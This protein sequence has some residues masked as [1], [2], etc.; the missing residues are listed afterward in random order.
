[1]PHSFLDIDALTL[2]RRVHAREISCR[3]VMEATL[4]RVAERNPAVTAIV[5]LR[6]PEALLREADARDAE[7]AAGRSRGWMHGFPQAP[8]DLAGTRDIATSRGSPLFAGKSAAADAASVERLVGAGAILIGKTN[9]PEFGLG[10]QTY[11]TVFGPTGNAYDPRLTSGGS[12]GGAAVAVALAMLPVADGSDMMGSLRNPAAYNNIFGFRPSCGRVPRAPAAEIFFQQLGYEG[13]MA[14]SVAD[15]ARLLATMAGYDPRAPLSLGDDPAAF[16][17]PLDA[18]VKDTRIGWLGDLGGYL[19][20][21]PGILDLC[22]T[23]L[24][25]FDDLGCIVDTTEAGFSMDAL[26]E[27]WITLRSFFVAGDL[28]ALHADPDRRARLKPEA[29]WEIERGLALSGSQVFAASATRTAWYGRL[30]ALFDRFDVLALPSAQVFA[31]DKTVPWPKSVAGRAMDT[32]HRWMEVVIPASMGGVPT[33]SVPA[34]FDAAG[35]AMGVQLIGRPRGD[36]DLLR[37]AHAYDLATRW[38]QRHPPR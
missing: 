29:V 15:L 4:A 8:K 12:S 21:E 20:F 30:L 32:Y 7:L 2:S 17:A 31:F 14:R 1:M 5:S 13:P 26:W 6:E 9:T 16:A 18:D 34:G 33:I 10:S 22:E 19:P 37:I 11:N 35:R 3:D 28:G 23:A 25:A 27:A 24:G 36:F 38:P